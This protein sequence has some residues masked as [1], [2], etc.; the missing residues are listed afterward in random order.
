MHQHY[1]LFRNLHFANRA[2]C[3]LLFVTREENG[4]Q[5]SEI[6]QIAPYIAADDEMPLTKIDGSQLYALPPFVDLH[7]HLTV[8][9]HGEDELRLSQACGGFDRALAV[10]DGKT[11]AQT[12]SAYAAY[13]KENSLCRFLRTAPP[14]KEELLPALRALREAGVAAIC[15]H[16]CAISDTAYLFD[17]MQA[18]AQEKMPLFC[19]TQDNAF[20]RGGASNRTLAKKCNLPYSPPIAEAAQVAKLLALARASGCRIHLQAIS[21]AQSVEM[22]RQA[23]AHGLAVTCETTPAY[24]TL[25][26]SELLFSGGEVARFDPPLRSTVDVE[27]VQQGIVDGTID[28]IA[29]DNSPYPCP[30]AGCECATAETAFAL[31]YMAFVRTGKMTIADLTDKFCKNPC[32]ILSLPYHGHDGIEVGA[33]ANFS[34]IYV[35]EEVLQPQYLRC[36][37]HKSPFLGQCLCGMVGAIVK[38]GSLTALLQDAIVRLP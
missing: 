5:S 19:D 3:D 7:C 32:T 2:P 29:T 10:L 36:R 22:I 4:V 14:P 31:S 21:T 27:A 20:V 33:C 11:D 37:S 38:D 13:T 6:L 1:T 23:K 12:A 35:G 15:D 24:F 30:A 9:E 34:L 25:N 28:V 17:L 26:Q 18:C 8:Q 16:G